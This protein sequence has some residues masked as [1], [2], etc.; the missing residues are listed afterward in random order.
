MGRENEN[1]LQAP[2]IN[3]DELA[4]LAFRGMM[5]G[6]QKEKHSKDGKNSKDG[7]KKG[8]GPGRGIGGWDGAAENYNRMVQMEKRYTLKQ[9]DCLDITKDDTVLD[10]CCGPGR[11][12]VPIAARAKSVT[13][14]DASPKM[15]EYLDKYAAEEGVTNYKTILQDWEDKD[16]ALQV[17]QHDIVVT[18]RSLGLHDVG[19]LSRLA[20]KTVMMTVWANGAKSIPQ[21]TGALFRDVVN[22][23]EEKGYHH[24]PFPKMD[25]R[26]GNNIFYN[27]VYD[28]GYEPNVRILDDGWERTFSSRDEAYNELFKLAPAFLAEKKINMD[29]FHAN[30]DKFLT[31]VDGSVTYFAP[32]KSF[33]IWWDTNNDK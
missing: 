20:R 5:P 21:I 14:L 33:V 18:S 9:I 6:S 26:L 27:K 28:L 22:E 16:A 10:V 29:I 8:M 1:D 24:P 2:F 12:V 7:E 31:D 13:G 32:T 25:R 15:L 4:K 23:D 11:L 17:P 30:V 19:I 3:W